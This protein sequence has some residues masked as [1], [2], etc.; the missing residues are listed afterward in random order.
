MAD[1]PLRLS[2]RVRSVLVLLLAILPPVTVFLWTTARWQEHELSE[3][4]EAALRLA[5]HA[6]DAIRQPGTPPDEVGL[7]TQF[8]LGE[9]LPESAVVSLLD[10]KGRVVSSVPP[11]ASRGWTFAPPLLQ[12]RQGAGREQRAWTEAVQGERVVAFAE[13]PASRAGAARFL[14]VA[15]SR[16]PLS[17]A[18]SRVLTLAWVGFALAVMMAIATVWLGTEAIVGRRVKALV[19]AATELSRGQL[20]ARTGLPRGRGELD[21]LA[22]AFDDMAAALQA[23]QEQLLRQGERLAAQEREL[24]LRVRERTAELVAANEALRAEVAERQRAEQAAR[25][26]SLVIEQTDDSVLITDRNGVIEYVN[27]AFEHM[28][29][30]SRGEAVGATPRI[31]SSGQH[32]ARFYADLWSTLL[33]GRVFRSVFTNRKKSGE[34]YFEDQT[35]TPIKDAGGDVIHFVST[36]RDITRRRR[37]EEA[38]RRLQDRFEQETK[39]IAWMLHDEAGQLLTAAHITLADTARA[40]SPPLRERLEGVRRDLDQVEEQLRRLSHEL[41]PGILDDLGLVGAVTFVAE[42]VSRRTGIA[43]DVD[44]AVNRSCS[45]LVETAIYRLVQEGLNNVAKHAHAR[46]GSVVLRQND[47]EV[48]CVVRDDGLGFEAGAVAARRGSRALGLS[49]IRDRVEAL[50]GLFS[51]VSAPGHGTELLAVMPFAS[52]D[53]D[54]DGT[55]STAP[56]VREPEA[57]KPGLAQ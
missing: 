44:A 52:E 24:E 5:R 10:A 18:A 46:R 19:A 40:S 25:T 2:L 21:R 47:H 51:V 12:T 3:M 27:T 13:L 22:A 38:L 30:Y 48:S 16:S 23:R 8:V 1:A 57:R 56:P 31:V 29:G 39:R 4:H 34:V 41:H 37:M 28:T 33:S 35:L 55:P 6:A 49:G 20:H 53:G 11:E 15:L 50:G 43:I 26:M 54:S 45:R 7:L 32:D 14:A 9:S 42:G 17:A 36:G